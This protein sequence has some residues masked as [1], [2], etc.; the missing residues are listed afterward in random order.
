V[1]H[2]LNL[3]R[4]LLSVQ[5]RSQ[6]QYRVSFGLDV[7]GVALVAFVEYFSVYLVLQRFGSIGGWTLG[8]VSLLFGLSTTAFGVMDM[9]FSGFDP[10]AFGN[11]IRRGDF[12]RLLL[13][14]VN[15]TLQVL[16]AAFAMR[17]L[18]RIFQGVLILAIA[19]A[20]LDMVWT[21]PKLLFLAL[22]FGGQVLYF[23]ALFI[24]GATVSFWTVESIEAVNIFTYGGQEMIAYPMHIYQDWIRMFFTYILPAIFLNYY[25]VL[26]VLGLPDPFGMPAWVHWLGPLVG[27]GLMLVAL[28]FWQFG[29]RSYQSTGT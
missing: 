10:E 3:Y 19:F 24:I 5:I 23:G 26:Y 27:L 12:D 13:R 8:E 7:A 4:R 25:P 9:L 1:R 2:A 15:I 29:I 22:V 14:P 28:R 20:N 21:L 6:M 11:S 18:G 17:R 16:G